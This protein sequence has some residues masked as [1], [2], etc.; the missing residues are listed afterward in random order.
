MRASPLKHL[1]ALL[2]PLALVWVVAP[3]AASPLPWVSVATA[4]VVAGLCLAGPGATAVGTGPQAWLAGLLAWGALDAALRPVATCDA[5]RLLAVGLVALGVVVVVGTPR[6]AAWGRLAAVVAGTGT[7]SWLAVER[8]LQPGRP[9]GPFGN[10]NLAATPALLALALAPRLRA[11]LLA[12]GVLMAVASAGIAASGSRA[13]LLG[14]IAV[15][16][17]WAI[18]SRGDRRLRLAA[19]LLVALALAGLSVR[20][21]LDR[22]PLRYERVRIWAVAARVAAAEFPLGC[23]PSGYADVAVAHN[24]PRDG[25]FA[26]YARLPDVAESDVLQLVATLGVPGV[27]LL[28][29]LGWSV[30]R[31]VPANDPYAWGVLAAGLVTCAFNSQLMVPTVAWTLALAAGSVVPR[32]GLRLEGAR[33]WGTT[34]AVLALAVGSG[35]VL[36]L[37]DFGAGEPPERLADRAEAILRMRPGDTGELADAEALAWRAC[38]ARPRFGRGWR[39]LGNLRLRRA[40]LRGEADVADAAVEAFARARKVNPLDVWATVGEGQARRTLG[41]TRG[42]FEAFNAALLLEPNCVPAW[43]ERAVLY[44]A[45]GELGP[46]RAALRSAEAAAARARGT[47]FVSGYERTLAWADPLTLARLRSATG[48]A[49]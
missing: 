21:V 43:L 24:F 48:E 15:A 40:A 9:A 30:A 23:G 5:A 38:A 35:A 28:A 45:Q 44:L 6:A 33:R 25:E 42:A 17:T 1:P 26:R 37:P 18:A 3:E 10:P 46:A 27:V 41:D 39:V 31:R 32:A 16:V 19:A 34:A 13:A 49:R 20:L 36:A 11:P 47:A 12:R 2:V 7:A 14:L 22:D 8:L 29:G 4:M